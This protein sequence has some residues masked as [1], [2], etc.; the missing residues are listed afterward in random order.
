MTTIKRRI[1]KAV[2]GMTAL[3]FTV[4]AKAETYIK[5][6]GKRE[7][8][9]VPIRI[10][11]INL[12][13]EAK[14]PD[15]LNRMGEVIA[16]TIL[17]GSAASEFDEQMELLDYP[18]SAKAWAMAVLWFTYSK[19]LKDDWYE[20]YVKWN[21]HYDNNTSD[22]SDRN[23][24]LRDFGMTD[25]AIKRSIKAATVRGIKSKKMKLALR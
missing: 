9:G 25:L 11:G 1:D 18:V 21:E 6:K 20:V 5:H 13:G 16:V 19:G 14:N 12:K 10:D 8:I 22:A 7:V 3:K 17:K 4:Y 24:I 15:I 23:K 2:E